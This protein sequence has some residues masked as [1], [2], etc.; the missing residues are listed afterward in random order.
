ML[1][2]YSNSNQVPDETVPVTATVK[3][4]FAL[5]MNEN[6]GTM[7]PQVHDGAHLG[8]H[9]SGSMNRT[10][11]YPNTRDTVQPSTG[12]SM[13]NLLT[14]PQVEKASKVDV[15][16]LDIR[17]HEGGTPMLNRSAGE[18]MS[19]DF[20]V[21]QA[22]AGTY[23][24]VAGV[25]P[26]EE[27]S[28]VLVNEYGRA[29][30]LV[31]RRVARQMVAGAQDEETVTQTVVPAVTAPNAPLSA[32]WKGM[33]R[34]ASINW[35]VVMDNEMVVGVVP[36]RAIMEAATDRLRSVGMHE[37]AGEILENVRMHNIQMDA[38]YN[39]LFG[40]TDVPDLDLCYCCT[41]DPSHCVDYRDQADQDPYG[42][43]ICPQDR[44]IMQP[45]AQCK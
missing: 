25:E 6:V 8:V 12:S 7:L 19:Q 22:T 24:K 18:V 38:L 28:I 4:M 29:V 41:S 33:L 3:P 23:A 32:L 11:S 30:G 43:P 27:H 34:D 37:D 16:V 15:V 5:S 20:S 17:H 9:V 36:P 26:S 35:Y 14:H 2:Y 13:N 21:V 31:A 39:P 40:E 1:L 10:L 42:N 44:T 45:H